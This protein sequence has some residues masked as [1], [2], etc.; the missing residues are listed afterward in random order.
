MIL[1]K[2]CV[3]PGVIAFVMVCFLLRQ[4]YGIL[5][6]QVDITKAVVCSDQAKVG[7]KVGHLPHDQSKFIPPT[8][9]ATSTLNRIR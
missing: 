8:L 7:D 1:R 6:L 3:H 2:S 9:F 5:Q 4:S